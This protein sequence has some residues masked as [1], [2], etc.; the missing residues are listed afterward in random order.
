MDNDANQKMHIETAKEFVNEHVIAMDHDYQK[1]GIVLV[2][3]L[4]GENG[5]T[6]QEFKRNY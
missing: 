4:F 6:K 2:L 3:S 1:K 5:A